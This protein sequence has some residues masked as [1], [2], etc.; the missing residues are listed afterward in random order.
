MCGRYVL[1]LLP[2]VLEL[3]F[4]EESEQPELELPWA[5][6]NVCPGTEAPIVDRD[7]VLRPALWGLIPFWSEAPPKRPLLNARLETAATRNSFRAAW[8]EQRCVVPT[9]GF[10][11]WSDLSGTRAPYY[12]PPPRDGALLWLAGLASRWK[13]PEGQKRWTYAVLTESSEGSALE[14]YHDRMP[15]T[16]KEGEV[17]AWLH[18][19]DP[20]GQR[21]PFAQPY[22]VSSKVNAARVNEPS[23]LEPVLEA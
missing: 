7:G 11:E 18:G 9:S 16:L 1:K 5:S 14:K 22:R 19:N 12:V 8:K 13:T 6:Y 17:E 15:V 2:G 23:N 4:V 20:P 10:Y 21:E 3:P